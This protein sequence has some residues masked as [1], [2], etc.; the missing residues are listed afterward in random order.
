MKEY[1]IVI[2]YGEGYG[3]EEYDDGFK[4]LNSALDAINYVRSYG[5]DLDF[6]IQERELSNWI[7]NETV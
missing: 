4:S 2:N 6:K 1:K 3:W 7:D 5:V